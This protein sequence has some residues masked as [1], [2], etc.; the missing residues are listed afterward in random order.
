M[1]ADEL[2]ALAKFDDVP[3]VVDTMAVWGLPYAAPLRKAYPDYATNND[4]APL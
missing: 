4:L 1:S 3:A 2:E